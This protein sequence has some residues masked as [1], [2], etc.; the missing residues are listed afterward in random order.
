MAFSADALLAPGKH[1]MPNPSTTSCCAKRNLLNRCPYGTP[2]RRRLHTSRLDMLNRPQ[3]CFI[4]LLKLPR[5]EDMFLVAIASRKD[6]QGTMQRRRQM[7]AEDWSG[8]FPHRS[9]T[10]FEE[11]HPV[12]RHALRQL[13][14]CRLSHICSPSSKGESRYA[15]ST[16]GLS[17]QKAI[18][19]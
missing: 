11:V 6:Q 7:E 10:S 13:P 18:F 2:P 17:P 15:G 1:C 12:T 14:A 19:E 9:S 16:C 3:F 4:Q 5:K 8:A